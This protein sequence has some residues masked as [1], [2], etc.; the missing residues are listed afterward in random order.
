MFFLFLRNALRAIKAIIAHNVEFLFFLSFLFTN[1][2]E[3]S[4]DVHTLPALHFA[5]KKQSRTFNRRMFVYVCV[6]LC[7]C[8][9]V[10]V[11]VCVCLYMCVYICVFKRVSVFVFFVSENETLSCYLLA[12]EMA[13]Q[14]LSH[15][16][17]TIPLHFFLPRLGLFRYRSSPFLMLFRGN[18]NF[19]ETVLLFYILFVCSVLFTT[20]LTWK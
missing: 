18:R 6:C 20:F 19:R 1:L 16:V 3:D 17:F 13:N 12:I 9:G 7:L 15:H 11:C 10:F 14:K 4:L 5:R 8:M 2:L